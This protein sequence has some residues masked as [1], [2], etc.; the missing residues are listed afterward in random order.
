M[1][2]PDGAG[3][4]ASPQI[5]C[6]SGCATVPSTCCG[7]LV[8]EPI[9]SC[10]RRLLELL[11]P[12][13]LISCRHSPSVSLSSRRSLLTTSLPCFMELSR[14]SSV[15]PSSLKAFSWCCRPH[16]ARSAARLSGAAACCGAVVD[17]PDGGGCMRHLR[18]Q[19][20]MAATST[21]TSTQPPSAR[22]MARPGPASC[23]AD[24]SL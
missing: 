19:T 12:S 2:M 17:A 24:E 15:Y 23:G 13:W 3:L 7:P 4:D 9:G 11:A 16:A 20:N 10:I 5:F 8:D 21:A 1:L 6:D 22:P 18:C 14:L